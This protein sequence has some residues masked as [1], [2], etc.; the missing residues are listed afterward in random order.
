M[1]HLIHSIPT[2]HAYKIR[3][4]S[5]TGC[6]SWVDEFEWNG[7][8][9]FSPLLSVDAALDFRALCGGE[10]RITKYCHHLAVEGGEAVAKI[11]G[12]EIMRNKEGEGDLIANMVSLPSDEAEDTGTDAKV[13]VG[14]C[15]TPD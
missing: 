4:S 1:Q 10:E 5:P 14:E 13:R 11:L 8:I 7:T 3:T 9:D 2:G 6:P 12:T 15:E